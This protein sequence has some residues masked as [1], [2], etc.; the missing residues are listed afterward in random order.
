MILK[1]T[2]GLISQPSLILVKDYLKITITLFKKN[3]QRF[4]HYVTLIFSVEGYSTTTFEETVEPTPSY[5][6]AFIVSDFTFTEL[7]NNVGFPQRVY[8][9]PNIIQ[10]SNFALET[11]VKSLDAFEAYFGIKFTFPKM[12][13]VAVPDFSAGAMENWG[14][15][16]YR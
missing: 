10:H 15:V 14:L 5:L 1:T 6:Y 12:D 2:S 16:T 8:S 3:N 9:R 11:G 7:K 4:N 13:Q